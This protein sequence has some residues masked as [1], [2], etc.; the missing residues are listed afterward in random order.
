MRLWLVAVVVVAP[1]PRLRPRGLPGRRRSAAARSSSRLGSEPACLNSC[2]RGAV[3]AGITASGSRK[4]LARPFDVG[5]DFTSSRAS[6]RGS[7]SREAPFTLTYHIRPE[8][9]WSDGVPV[10]AQ[11]F[12]F[13][14]QAIRHARDPGVRR[15]GAPR[16]GPQ[17][18]RPSMQRRSGSSF[19]SR[20]PTGRT[21]S[22][23]ASAPRARGQDLTKVW[24]DRIDN[25]K[26]GAPI[27]SGPFLVGRLERGKQLTLV[28]NPRYWGPH[29]AYL[30]RFVFRFNLDPRDPLGPLRRGELDFTLAAGSCVHQ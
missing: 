4:V 30:D 12:L 21:C 2:S 14:H 28:R 26:T 20:S 25:P 24:I 8:A 1:S 19:A 7:T 18:A 17:R 27:G 29:T 9:R 10:T 3:V 5:P 11:D 16:Q 22:D 13:T 15:K 23:R 6:S